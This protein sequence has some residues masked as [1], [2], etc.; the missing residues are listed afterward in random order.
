[1]S[2]SPLCLA[3]PV[4]CPLPQ[5]PST[6]YS[7]QSLPSPLHLGPAW[8]RFLLL[9]SSLPF[10]CPGVC[11][12]ACWCPL[13]ELWSL[14]PAALATSS[15]VAYTA[16][17]DSDQVCCLHATP[18]SPR[19]H[20]GVGFLLMLPSSSPV[21]AAVPAPAGALYGCGRRPA[22]RARLPL[23]PAA[24]AN[25]A[26]SM[27][28]TPCRRQPAALSSL[29]SHSF[30]GWGQAQSASCRSPASA[31]LSRRRR[32]AASRL[33]G[34]FTCRSARDDVAPYFKTEP[35]LPQIHLEGN[36][37]VLT[38]LAEGSWPLE[39]KWL[40]NDVEVTAFSSKYK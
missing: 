19:S 31:D 34:A 26:K 5:Q 33:H 22:E 10:A 1:M 35:G 18:L 13:W 7:L 38:C 25:S 32:A 17:A 11:P 37:L 39:F 3:T 27:G 6:F 14:R 2:F 4:H 21:R 29:W 24:L 12:S 9:L 8:A 23:P 20:L 36:R 16:L 15:P 30:A 28:S 40:H